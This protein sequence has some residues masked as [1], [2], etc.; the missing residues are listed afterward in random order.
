MTST[1]SQRALDYLEQ[2]PGT[3]FTKLY[4]QPSTA[5]AIFRRMLPHL[6]KTLVMAIL[7]MPTPLSVSDLETWVKPDHESLQARDRA[8]SI[9][10]RLRILFD[11]HDAAGRAAYKLSD[12]FARSLRLALTGGGNHRSF[13][14]P[15]STPDKT[16][17]SIDY[18]DT[19]ARKQWEAI[20]YYVVGSA[21]AGL[22]AEV[23][24]SAGTKQLLQKGEFVAMRGRTAH[25]TQAG[26]T[27]LLQEINAQIWTLLIVYLEVSSSLQMDP[28]DVLS[29]LF[30]LGSL[31][32][33]ISYSTSNLT[34]T[35]QQ[36]LED[37]AD[38][39]LV[40]RRTSDD[41][42]D[43]YYPTRLAT[44]L[45]SD[46]PA[47]PNASLTSTA[48]GMTTGGAGGASAPQNEKGYIIVETNYRLYAYTSSPLP[49]SILSLF[50]TLHTR[51]PNL[52]TAKITKSSIHAA[53]TAGITS[54]QII[55]YLTTH[56]HPILRRQQ[57]VLPPTVVDQIR[58]WQIEGERMTA[59]RGYL[60][61]DVG[62]AEEYEKAVAYAEALGV[63]RKEFKA[64]GSFFVTR[65]DQMSGYFKAQAVRKREA[66]AQR[67]AEARGGGGGAGRK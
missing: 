56:A 9:L 32:L 39:G 19:F 49:I 61:R 43:R 58:L 42:A 16:P 59:W 66:I 40:Y 8:L 13:G 57:P 20:L 7:Y 29:F 25:I 26:F 60:I 35:Q 46:A 28:V 41:A 22:G 11:T 38:F 33:G 63:L 3:T 64:K 23:D 1:A 37:L 15:C 36:M 14:V 62:S 34:P 5:L 30:T 53:I 2:L 54:D 17:V 51:Y 65:M 47:L 67:E 10:Q 18:L 24:I 27:F 31:E 52:I 12:A 50:A 55:T 21:S 48:T 4:Q 45:T 6:A 44:T